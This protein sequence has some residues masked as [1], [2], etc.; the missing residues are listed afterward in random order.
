[1][2]CL[3]MFKNTRQLNQRIDQYFLGCNAVQAVDENNMLLFDKNSLPIMSSLEKP[4]T[5]TG[6]ALA[7]GFNSRSALLEF[8]GNQVH[9]DIISR[10]LARIEEFAE[11][12]LFDKGL[13]TGAKFFLANNFK[14]WSDKPPAD[15]LDTLAKLDSVMSDI[16]KLMKIQL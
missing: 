4:P 14:N 2:N 7:I 9:V 5:V 1:M 8:N 6:L 10:A 15:D 11:A 12:K 16:S 13:Y 3:N